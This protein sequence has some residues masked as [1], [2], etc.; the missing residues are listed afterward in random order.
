MF[1][2]LFSSKGKTVKESERPVIAGR[3][4]SPSTESAS[5]SASAATG[6]PGSPTRVALPPSPSPSPELDPAALHS[7]IKTCPPKTLHAYTVSQ[8][9]LGDPAPFAVLL[10]SHEMAVS[11]PPPQ[12]CMHSRRSSGLSSH[13]HGCTV[14]VVIK[15]TLRSKTTTAA[16]RCRTMTRAQKSNI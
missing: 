11:Q 8:L 2:R 12:S 7:L 15:V 14:C 5:I 16:A 6:A 9:E 1:L 13:R 4:P 10:S 3:S